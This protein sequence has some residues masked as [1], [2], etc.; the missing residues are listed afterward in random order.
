[1]KESP[2]QNRFW[3]G[4]GVLVVALVVLLAM[5]LLWEVIGMWAMVLWVALVG[6]GVYLVISDRRE[7]PSFHD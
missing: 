2:K 3:A 5:D 6:M 1:M 4:N 7:P